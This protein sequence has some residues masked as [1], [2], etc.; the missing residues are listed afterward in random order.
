MINQVLCKKNTKLTQFPQFFACKWFQVKIF[1][2]CSILQNMFGNFWFDVFLFFFSSSF[3][4]SSNRYFLFCT[5]NSA[6]TARNWLLYQKIHVSFSIQIQMSTTIYP[7]SFVYVYI[8]IW[9]LSIH[10]ILHGS[11]CFQ[12]CMHNLLEYERNFVWKYIDPKFYSKI[13]HQQ[14]NIPKKCK[15]RIKLQKKNSCCYWF[16]KM[17]TNMVLESRD[18]THK[19]CLKQKERWYMTHTHSN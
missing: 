14:E 11:T 17:K 10:G 16:L 4:V 3:S 12:F 5:R 15:K 1:Q 8:Y 2:R 7:F 9:V 13:E 19:R 18:T 6:C